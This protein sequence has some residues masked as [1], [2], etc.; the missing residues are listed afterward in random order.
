MKSMTRVLL[1]GTLPLLVVFVP[2]IASATTT[3][4][5][6]FTDVGPL[7]LNGN[8]A[9]A[10][11]GNTLLR[12]TPNQNNQVGSAFLKAPVPFPAG[13]SFHSY[14]RARFWPNA[15]GADGIS[16][17]LQNSNAGAS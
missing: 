14:F 3:N 5:C 16:F 12:V 6:S 9:Q 15:A 10:G 17:I 4:F 8:A 2:D 11:P 13:T 1:A 7:Q